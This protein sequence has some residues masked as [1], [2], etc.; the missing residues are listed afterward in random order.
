MVR[1]SKFHIPLLILYGVSIIGL[2]LWLAIFPIQRATDQVLVELFNALEGL[3][4]DASVIQWYIIVVVSAA[5]IG[6]VWSKL[7]GRLKLFRTFLLIIG[8]TI[9][10][11]LLLA[12][13]SNFIP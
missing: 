2:V 13:L 9:G 12:L 7:N 6:S 4:Y 1:S 11:F 8:F 10:T 3:F 5:L